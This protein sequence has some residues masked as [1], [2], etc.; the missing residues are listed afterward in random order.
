MTTKEIQELVYSLMRGIDKK[1]ELTVALRSDASE[2]AVTVQLR[3]AKRTA[4]LNLTEAELVGAKSD[5]IQRNR[6]R[7][8]L[9]R[10][11]DK[12]WTKNDYI[13]STKME[14][15]KLEAGGYFQSNQRS[16][17]RR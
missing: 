1:T 13:F 12:M 4:S 10:A 11:H 7:T 2:P 9:K 14:S 17:G 6:V 3:N 5:L 15:H 8:A 16:R